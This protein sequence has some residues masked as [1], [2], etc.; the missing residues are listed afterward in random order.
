MRVTQL[1]E[2]ASAAGLRQRGFEEKAGVHVCRLYE[3]FYT[4]G[5]YDSPPCLPATL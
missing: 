1:R 4:A 2:Y 5:R 3:D